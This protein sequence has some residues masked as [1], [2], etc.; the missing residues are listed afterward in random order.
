M[1]HA[2]LDI[3]RT[4]AD[5]WRE[6]RALRLE[7]LADTPI[8]YGETL[9]A[10]ELRDEAGWRERAAR[11]EDPRQTLLAAISGGRWVGTM[12]GYIS[13]QATGAMLVA[14]YVAPD[15]R[16]EDAGVADA[17]LAGVEAWALGFGDTLTLEVHEANPRAIRFYERHGFALTGHRREYELP[18]GGLEL[19]MRK[20]LR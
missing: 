14:V 4:T 9:A 1:P 3:R 18:P 2:A 17:L 16:G 5:D 12:A 7:M 8:A 13:D 10:A 15:F 19:E 6:Y 20:R 11:G